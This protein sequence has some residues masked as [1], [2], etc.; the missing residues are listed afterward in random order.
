[1]HRQKSRL[2]AQAMWD[3]DQ[4]IA[5]AMRD[6]DRDVK[7]KKQDGTVTGFRSHKVVSISAVAEWK[8]CS[9]WVSTNKSC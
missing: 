5:Q 2:I 8:T 1:L 4:L 7:K 6:Y 3:Y 9:G